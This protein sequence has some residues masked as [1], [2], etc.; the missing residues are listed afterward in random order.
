M[1]INN[2][3]LQGWLMDIGASSRCWH[4]ERRGCAWPGYYG[5]H[6]GVG[7]DG[8]FLVDAAYEDADVNGAGEEGG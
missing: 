8:L 4:S 5:D 6:C 7:A 1:K 3:K 2:H